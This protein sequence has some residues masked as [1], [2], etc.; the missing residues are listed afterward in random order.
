MRPYVFL[1]SII[2]VIS[3]IPNSNAGEPKHL[4]DVGSVFGGVHITTNTS[5]NV[6]MNLSE[7][8]A[9][10]EDYTATWCENCIDVEHALNDVE[11]QNH[12]IQY[13]FHRFID[14]NED[15]L[16]F[17]EGDD[18]WIERYENRL[19]PTAIFNGTL[20]QV[21]SVANGNSLQEDYNKH[22]ENHLNLGEGSSS[23]G[24]IAGTN[25]SNPIVT[26]NLIIDMGVFPENSTISSSIWVVED[27][28]YFPD[29]S[30][31]EEYYHES[32]RAIIDLGENHSGSKEITLPQAFDGD[33]LEIHLIHEVVLPESTDNNEEN[34]EEPKEDKE[35]EDGLPALGLISVLMV[36]T[37]AAVIVQRKQQ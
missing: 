4:D 25:N 33:D 36:S 37:F 3:T 11:E 12:M 30:N 34:V 23:L 5:G 26:W 14:E 15:P 24:Y 13:H 8:P 27:V 28:A 35:D 7:L 2:I 6:S 19:P 9:I 10:V 21:G 1:I 20:M 29:G 16:G 17:Q 32:V 18:R 31:G 22:L